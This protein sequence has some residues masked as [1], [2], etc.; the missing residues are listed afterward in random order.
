MLISRIESSARIES[1]QP[2]PAGPKDLQQAGALAEAEGAERLSF[3][4]DETAAT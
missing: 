3:T 4:G 1:S 2:A